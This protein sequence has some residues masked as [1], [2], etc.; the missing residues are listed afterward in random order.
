MPV[1]INKYFLLI[2]EKNLAQIPF[3]GFERNAK[4]PH[5]NSEKWRHWA[6]D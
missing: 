1:V 3:V 2:P 6:E 4:I 5:F